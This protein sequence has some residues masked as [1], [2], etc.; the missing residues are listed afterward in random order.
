M[1][2]PMWP[3][4]PQLSSGEHSTNQLLK[5]WWD[6]VFFKDTD[7]TNRFSSLKILKFCHSS[8]ATTSVNR[9][10]IHFLFVPNHVFLH[11]RAFVLKKRTLC[12]TPTHTHF[13]TPSSPCPAFLLH[14]RLRLKCWT[15]AV[16][17]R[18]PSE[19][20]QARGEGST[21]AVL[22]MVQRQKV[23]FQ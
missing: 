21:N 9:L 11:Q 22:S 16:S 7:L 15:D 6:C 14:V 12:Y 4:F 19:Y 3:T 10:K 1:A 17:P 13:K 18:L 5:Q 23:I 8:L 2:T 20:P